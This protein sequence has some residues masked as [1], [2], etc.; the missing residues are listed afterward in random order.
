MKRKIV[1]LIG[2][3]V[4]WDDSLPVVDLFWWGPDTKHCTYWM[5]RQRLSGWF[6]CPRKGHDW[7]DDMCGKPEHDICA[8]CDIRRNQ[9]VPA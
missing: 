6:V 5:W 1:V 3:F 8:R 2:W 4:D 9:A 7:Y